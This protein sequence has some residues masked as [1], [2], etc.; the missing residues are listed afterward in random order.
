MYSIDIYVVLF[1]LSFASP[2]VIALPLHL[3]QP[4]V[5]LSDLLAKLRECHINPSRDLYLPLC[6]LRFASVIRS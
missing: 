4:L 6:H 3:Q 2:F 1:L 5:A